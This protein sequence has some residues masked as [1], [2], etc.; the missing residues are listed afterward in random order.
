MARTSSAVT[1]VR[2]SIA[3]R[4]SGRWELTWSR[5]TGSMA[6]ATLSGSARATLGRID[7]VGGQAGASGVVEPGPHRHAHVGGVL[8]EDLALTVELGEHLAPGPRHQQLGHR[9]EGAQPVA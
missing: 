6:A 7:D 3:R 5:T 9:R 2:A 1:V 4:A 8:V